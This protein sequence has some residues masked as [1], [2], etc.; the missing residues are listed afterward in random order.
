MT[1]KKQDQKIN[2]AVMFGG[3]S[4]EHAVSL[5]SA[6]FVLSQLNPEKYNVIQVGITRQGEWFTGEDVLSA[7]LAG[8]T[9][10]LTVVT[11]LPVPG[12][13]GLYRVEAGEPLSLLA[14]V[15]VVFPVLHGTFGEDGTLQGLLELAEVAYVGPGVTGSAVGMDK[16]VFFD[17]MRA[18]QIPVVDTILVLRSEME[19]DPSAVLDA[20]EVLGEYPYFVK[21][22]NLGSSVGISKVRNRSDLMEGLMEAAAYDRRLVVQKGLNVREIEV[23]VMGND[24]PLASVCGEVLPGEEFYS[25][26]AKYHDDRSRTVIPADIP[27]ELSERIRQVAVRAFQA[28]DLAGLARVDFFI[29]RDSGEIYLNELNTIPGFTQISMYPMLWKASGVENM[30]LIDQLVAYAMARKAQRDATKRT[31]ERG[32]A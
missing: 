24:Q 8:R 13:P 5:E 29:D 21:P 7:M 23:A 11:M 27:E 25:Y 32:Q 28:C 3:R 17:V 30:A 9:D 4:G 10:G 18:N 31:F 26:D 12:N 19:N 22:A 15:D 14:E 1:E 2:I 20:V 6:K 16:G